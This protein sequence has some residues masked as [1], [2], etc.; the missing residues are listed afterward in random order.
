MRTPRIRIIRTLRASRRYSPLR[1]QQRAALLHHTMFLKCAPH[2]RGCNSSVLYYV[3]G[4]VISIPVL[5]VSS[6][7]P[8]KQWVSR[9]VGANCRRVRTRVST[10]TALVAA[11]RSRHGRRRRR[12]PPSVAAVGRRRRPTPLHSPRPRVLPPCRVAYSR[13][14]GRRIHSWAAV[15]R[16]VLRRSHA[17]GRA[18]ARASAA[19]THCPQVRTQHA[20]G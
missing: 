13:T 11:R 4:S 16:R 3:F 7:S 20:C 2:V 1:G 5:W 15:E 6:T 8:L 14:G 9:V 18:G 12:S 19:E 10:G 17:H